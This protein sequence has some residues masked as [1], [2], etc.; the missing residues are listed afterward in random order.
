MQDNPFFSPWTAPQGA[1]PFASIRP[2]HYA[3][4][5]AEAM[6]R[7]RAEIEAIANAPSPPSFV[8]TIEALER[9]GHMLGEVSSVFSNLNAAN[10]SDETRAIE[11]DIAPILAQHGSYIGLHPGLFA[12]VAALYARRDTLGLDPVQMRLLERKHLG[13]VRKGASLDAAGRA[14][15]EAI[16]AR[17]AVLHTEFGQNVLHDEQDWSLKLEEADLEGLPDF[18]REGTHQAAVE[19]GVEGRVVT[20]SRS[21]IEPFL[22]FSPR[23][24]LRKTAYL[25]WIARGT[26]AG[27][28]DNTAIIPEILALRR[29]QARLLGYA[30]FAEYRL[31]DSM[32]GTP[33]AA[34]RLTDEV[35][36][37]ALRKA[38]AERALLQEDARADG[39]IEAL[40][41]WDWAFYAERVRRARFAIDEADLKPYFVFANIQNAAFDTAKK[42][43]G[44]DFIPRPDIAAYHPDVTIFEAREGGRHVGLFVSDPF[45]RAGKR[46]GAW[47]SSFRDQ[48]KLSGAISPIV[49]NVNNFAKSTPTLLSFDDTET[50]FHE[51]GHALHGLLSD[52]RYPSQSGTS[53]RRDFVEF[54]SQIMEHWVSARATLRRYATH[55]QSGEPIPDALIDK[56]EA[57]RNFNQGFAT[58]E[59]TAAAILDLELHRHPDP[60]KLDVIG[61]E[62]DVLARIGLPHDIGV[63]HRAAHFQHLF[64]GS[65]YSASYYAY[66]WAEVLD[67]DGFDAFEQKGDLFDPALAAGLRRVLSAGDSE[68]PMSLYVGFR[69]HAPQTAPLMRQRGLVE[70]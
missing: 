15:M 17:L 56:L 11:R 29:E 5:F 23:R 30:D 41:P 12:R 67:A 54:P 34:R 10:G 58:V 9:S 42:L 66:L 61:F 46:S 44:L 68:D 39:L 2:E 22:K 37:A 26:H 43:F 49:I 62:R 53:V 50:L 8:N 6:A 20:L 45:A 59:Y 7:H 14:R 70:A 48:E 27:A 16:A 24:D 55:W 65:G 33:E 51:F 3:P 63:R 38:A 13:F 21:L 52:V 1:P 4:A 35:W 40:E 19:R 47:M 31:A 57:A 60:A 64:A 28:H 69:G 36:P 18:L 32:A 25:A